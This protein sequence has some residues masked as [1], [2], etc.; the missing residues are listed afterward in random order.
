M[1]PNAN[2]FGNAR[3]EA[4]LLAAAAALGALDAIADVWDAVAVD[5]LPV[6]DD[7]VRMAWLVFRA[8]APQGLS[9]K[10]FQGFSLDSLLFGTHN[11]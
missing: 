1:V 5:R 4:V 6:V 9:C 3:V 11:S 10:L 8:V 2:K 7:G